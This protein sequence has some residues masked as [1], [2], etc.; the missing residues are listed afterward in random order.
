[1]NEC[2]IYAV[3]SSSPHNLVVSELLPR[4]INIKWSPPTP[5]DR[6]GVI[7]KYLINITGKFEDILQPTLI[8]ESYNTSIL[9]LD[10]YPNS[11][12]TISVSAFTIGAGPFTSEL[13]VTTL[14]DGKLF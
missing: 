1:M 6:N 9:I 8:L 5:E 3:P 10:L 2:F 4:S 11:E 14:E 7:R 12:Y 13:S